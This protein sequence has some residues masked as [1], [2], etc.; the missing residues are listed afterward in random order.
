MPNDKPT[1]PCS[2]CG[3]TEWWWHEPSSLGDPEM[4][5]AAPLGAEAPFV[6]S[7]TEICEGCGVH[8]SPMVITGKRKKEQIITQAEGKAALW[9]PGDPIQ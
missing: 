8:Y 3:C 6:T 5:K 2:V 1:K 9:K 7:A 4:L